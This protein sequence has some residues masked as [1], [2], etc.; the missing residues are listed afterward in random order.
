[1]V[2]TETCSAE[3][4]LIGLSAQLL[5]KTS[6]GTGTLPHPQYERCGPDFVN[7]LWRSLTIESVDCSQSTESRCLVV[8]SLAEQK[9]G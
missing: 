2:R 3:F 9:P 4:N 1:M 7:Y 6:V 8:V 5:A